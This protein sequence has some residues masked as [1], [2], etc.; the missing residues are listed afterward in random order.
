MKS[1]AVRVEVA[2][3]G[4]NSWEPRMWL[5]DIRCSA[6]YGFEF[7]AF[8]DVIKLFLKIDLKVLSNSRV[9]AHEDGD[10]ISFWEQ[11]YVIG[12]TVSE[13]EWTGFWSET[14]QLRDYRN[15]ARSCSTYSPGFLIHTF[16]KTYSHCY[17]ATHR[18]WRIGIRCSGVTVLFELSYWFDRALPDSIFILSCLYVPGIA[19]SLVSSLVHFPWIAF[20]L[21]LKSA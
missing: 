12:M 7:M 18:Y 5:P 4:K 10:G 19:S 1:P 20:P 14:L 13:R 11:S 21:F 9:G 17:L 6:D 2:F 15:N 8:H 16:A 3:K